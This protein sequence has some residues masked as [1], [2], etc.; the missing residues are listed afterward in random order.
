MPPENEQRP[1]Q[2]ASIE[3]PSQVGTVE[4]SLIIAS[5]RVALN[6]EGIP[7]DLRKLPQWVDWQLMPP[8]K[9]GDKLGK[10]P[11]NPHTGAAASS[12]DAKTWST[13]PEALSRMERDQLAGVG[14]VFTGEGVVGIDL[15]HCRDAMTGGIE[16]W[17]M[18]IVK[19]LDT[20]TEI[21]PSG[22]GLHLIGRGVL[23][24]GG[25]RKGKIE[26]YDRARFFTITGVML[27]GTPPDVAD[28]TDPLT[29]LHAEVFGKARNEEPAHGAPVGPGVDDDDKLIER[30]SRGK[31]GARFKALYGGDFSVYSSQSEGDLALCNFLSS[32]TNGDAHRIDRLFRRSGLF[33]PKW[34]EQ[35]GESTYGDLTIRTAVASRSNGVERDVQEPAMFDGQ[36]RPLTDSGNAERLVE[37][38]GAD[39]RYVYKWNKW[40]GYESGRWTIDERGVAM[41]RSKQVARALYAEAA[42]CDDDKV[43]EATVKWARISE[44]AE[45]RK[46]MVDLARS[47][48]GVPATP[49][50]FDRHPFLINCP[51][52]TLDLET[53]DM[54]EHRRS[55]FLTKMCPTKYVA[56]AACPLWEKAIERVLPD[57]GVRKYLQRFCGYSLTGDVSEQAMMIAIGPGANGKSTLLNAFQY[58]MSP[59]YVIQVATDMLLSKDRENHPTDLADLFG[60]RM[61]IGTEIP[62]GRAL[63]EPK[64][65]LLTGGEPVRARRMREDFWQFDPSHKFVLVTNHMPRISM[66]DYA[67]T[68]R[69]HVVRFDVTIPEAERDRSLMRKLK[70]EREG[71][72]AWSVAGYRAWRDTGL[73]PPPEV[74]MSEKS[75]SRHKSSAEEFIDA[76]VLRELGVR[77]PATAL[78]AA[79]GTWCVTQDTPTT[80]QQDFGS[81]LGRKGFGSKKSNGVIVYVDTRLL[82]PKEPDR[83]DR[84]QQGPPS[85]LNGLGTAHDEENRES[86]PYCP[87]S[88]LTGGASTGSNADA[89]VLTPPP[90]QPCYACHGARF[91]R[92]REGI[93]WVCGTCAPPSEDLADVVWSVAGVIHA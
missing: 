16:P 37:R 30:A 14:F 12:T 64:V 63:D 17:A 54:R 22:T 49:M 67:M 81:Q 65:K 53:V 75:A 62:Q 26:M 56:N 45:R 80:T 82:P 42:N 6:V 27:A 20:Y 35:H 69:L 13:F 34:D 44:K 9:P 92:L 47:E 4:G 89:C 29:A 39:L 2:G 79:Y 1:G 77:T 76:F 33:R 88:S 51:N 25:K 84:G 46:A 38:F 43:R 61:A 74:I 11:I 90:K 31:S 55:D 21:S 15:D 24:A 50:I 5:P 40:L 93:V 59:A 28:I 18:E 60:V 66:N 85:L 57:D 91:W 78:F 8:K 72:L 48:H 19:K 86:G 52:G 10:L 23:P 73:A 41:A 32:H 7:P 58:T 71:I 68:R 87:Q 83:D 70:A 36:A 3:M